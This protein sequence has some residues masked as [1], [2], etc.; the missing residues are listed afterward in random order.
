MMPDLTQ[1]GP[2]VDP[3][4]P[5]PVDSKV[6]AVVF[7]HVSKTY[8]R[9]HAL[10]NINLAISGGVTGI[11]GLNGAGKSTLFNLLMGRCRP[12][13]GEVRLF[14]IDPWKDPSPYAR[15]GFVPES[16][17]LHDWMTA[18]DFVATFARLHGL[19]REQAQA[20]AERVLTFVGL[21]ENIHSEIGR[22]SKGMRQRVKIAH[23]LVNDP[24]LIVLDEP[25]TGCD[26][27]ARTT[28]MNVVRELGRIGRTVLVSSHI[29]HEIER[30]TEQIVLLHH[31]QVLALGNVHGIRA[32]LDRI[33]H[34]ILIHTDEANRLAKTTLDLEHVHGVLLPGEGM[35][36]ILT[37]D[38]GAVHSALPSLLVQGGFNVHRIDNPDDD[39]ESIIG[40]LVGGGGA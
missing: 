12:S 17:K 4:A 13:S 38:L 7:D 26:P 39:L 22:F 19:G 25:L 8:G 10:S 5:V 18:G 31:G 15:V 9:I 23:A 6:P 32:R 16:E 11:L 2:A 21:Q 27:L 28:I 34:R 24:D 33:P 40:H 29:L 35:V 37:H 20:E 1:V 3:A 30:I 14:G 36:E